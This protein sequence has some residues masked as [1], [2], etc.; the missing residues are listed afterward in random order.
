MSKTWQ[1]MINGSYQ[2]F[3]GAQLNLS[4]H[5][6]EEHGSSLNYLDF[7]FGVMCPHLFYETAVFL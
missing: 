2:K 4:L 5:F 6:M 3:L 7:S 1:P